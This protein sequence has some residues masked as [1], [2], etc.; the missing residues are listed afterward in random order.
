MKISNF[1]DIFNHKI[2]KFSLYV[3]CI[4]LLLSFFIIVYGY[5]FSSQLDCG[6]DAAIAV[7]SKNLASG[8]GYS[9]SIPFDGTYGISKFD[10]RISTGPTLVLPVALFIVIFGNT[11][12]V[13]GFMVSSI[14][15]VLLILIIRNIQKQMYLT[16]ALAFST[17]L[18]F[19]FYNITADLHFEQWFVLMGELPATFLCIFGVFILATSPDNRNFIISA[20]FL[21]GLAF[22]TKM[23]SLL[24]FL[25]LIAWF[26]FS[27]IKKKYNRKTLIINYLYGVLSFIT[28][29]LLFEVWKLFSLGITGYF[30]NTYDF[31]CFFSGLSGV[32]PGISFSVY[33]N[34]LQRS[35]IMSDHFGFSPILLF[36]VATILS[37]IVY[38]FA[39]RR[40]VRLVFAFL[41][42]GAFFHLLY[43]IFLSNGWHRY[44]L[45]GL[46]LYFTALSCILFVKLP[47]SI[48]FTIVLVLIIMFS[49]PLKRLKKP[50]SYVLEYRFNYNERLV[51]LLKT[52]EFLKD[53]EQNKPFISSLWA[54]I[55]D[56]EYAMPTLQNFKRFDQLNKNDSSRDLILVRNTK[57]INEFSYDEFDEWQRRWEEEILLHAPPYLVSRCIYV[58]KEFEPS[59]IIN[60]SNQGNSCDY[61]TYG[62]GKQEQSLRWTT[63]LNFGLEFSFN[64]I[65]KDSIEIQLLGFGYLAGGEIEYQTVS[66]F[67]DNHFAGEWKVKEEKWYTITIPSSMLSDDGSNYAHF[68]IMNAAAPASFGHSL[69]KRKLGLAVKMIYIYMK[70]TKVARSSQSK[71]GIKE[72]MI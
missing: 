62:W 4:S 32:Y 59:N 22:M 12:W 48:I 64:N 9:T 8:N 50:V 65:P 26:I 44:V 19:F 24:G 45:I 14:C 31:V 25:P 7:A 43:W 10:P 39:K 38:H 71:E 34:F 33:E 29:F 37:Y 51:N 2:I 72:H 57:F 35:K 41:M 27:L 63:G 1:S 23:I 5:V 15:L 70:A 20:C 61:I 49:R 66:I 52:V 18:I 47:H 36:L 54:S 68:E 53:Y 16:L 58:Q 13:P 42:L 30:E 69:D 40:Y 55:V 21:F 56:V 46:F 11:F 28:P 60:F 17:L 67:V 3:V 6:D